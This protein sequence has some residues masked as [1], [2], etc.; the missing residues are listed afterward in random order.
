MCVCVCVF[1]VVSISFVILEDVL[2]FLLYNKFIKQ[3]FEQ[4]S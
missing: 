1:A 3:A 2:L 4:S